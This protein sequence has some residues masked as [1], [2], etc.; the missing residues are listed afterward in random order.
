MPPRQ[1]PRTADTPA[2]LY[3]STACRIGTHP[4]CAESAPASA[5][6]DLPVIYEACDCPCH[7]ARDQSAPAEVAQ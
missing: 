6:V 5:S 2:A 1:Q 3:R 7:T 4:A